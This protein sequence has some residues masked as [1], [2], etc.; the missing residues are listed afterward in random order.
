[1]C[2]DTI[3]L[4]LSRLILIQVIQF[5][6]D[7]WTFFMFCSAHHPPTSLRQVSDGNVLRMWSRYSLTMM[8]ITWQV[9]S[10]SYGYC[11]CSF[12]LRLTAINLLYKNAFTCLLTFVDV[13]VYFVLCFFVDIKTFQ[14]NFYSKLMKRNE[15]LRK[16][17]LRRRAS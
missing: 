17:K 5:Q 10:L 4:F 9:S 1:M 2:V 14:F 16:M 3:S 15:N 8:L 11:V 12:D 13:V 6:L 7:K